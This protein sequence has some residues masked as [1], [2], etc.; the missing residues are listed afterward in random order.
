[1]SLAAFL[2]YILALFIAAIIPGPGITSIVGRAL[3]LGTMDSLAMG[4][5]LIVGDVIYLTA[6]ILGLSVVAQSFEL[7]FIALKYL[8]AA[9]LAYV[10]Y[11]IWTAG[12]MTADGLT[13]SRASLSKSFV[14]GLLL[15]LGNPKPMLFYI[16]LMPSI[17]PLAQ[18]RILDYLQLVAATVAVL[19]AVII[20][21]VALAVRAK[22]FMQNSTGQAFVNRGAAA[23]L[24][25]TAG[26][27][28]LN[29]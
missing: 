27:I 5:G 11:K 9:Y 15:T 4:V 18:I 13:Q 3:S 8:G 21:Y 1:M 28:A 16:A 23:I 19:L 26:F 29:A 7:V 25:L 24:A 20:A 22:A 10:A 12:M 2:A 17:I 6:V 14:N